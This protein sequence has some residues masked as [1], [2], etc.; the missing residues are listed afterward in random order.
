[1]G[2]QDLS[3]IQKEA[4]AEANGTVYEAICVESGPRVLLVLCATSREQ[5]K[6]IERVFALSEKR[7][8]CDWDNVTLSEIAMRTVTGEGLNYEDQC[9]KTGE[10][11]AIL[12]CAA[13]PKAMQVLETAFQIPR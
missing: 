13:S 8:S 2:N 6:S 12:L 3:R 9:N 5:I 7:G 11:T 10:R 1:V 4:A